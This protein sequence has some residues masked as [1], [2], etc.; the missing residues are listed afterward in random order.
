MSLMKKVGVIILL[1]ILLGIAWSVMRQ[2][3]IVPTPGGL[4][5]PL[6]LIYIIFEPVSL[7]YFLFVISLGLYTP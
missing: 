3:G 7:V 6:N 1:Y 5:G 4:D 2:F